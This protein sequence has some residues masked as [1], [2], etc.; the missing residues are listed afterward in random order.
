MAEDGH[1]RQFDED[2]VIVDDDRRLFQINTGLQR[3]AVCQ[4]EVLLCERYVPSV[5]LQAVVKF[6]DLAVLIFHRAEL[7]DLLQAGIDLF[8]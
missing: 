5:D 3:S 4:Q 8:L 7:V 2:A 6:S 1:R